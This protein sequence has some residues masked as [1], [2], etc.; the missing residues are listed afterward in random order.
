MICSPAFPLLIGACAILCIA[1]CRSASELSKVDANSRANGC[2][3]ASTVTDIDGNVYPVVQI[4]DQCWMAANLKT[5]RYRDG[6]I[7]P[8]ETDS[9]VWP[10]LTGGAWCHYGNSAVSDP[11]YGK[12][13]NWY[14]ASDPNICPQ[15]WHVPTDA[16]WAVLVD[17]L[18][19]KSIAGGRMKAVSPLWNAPNAGA[20]NES[21]FTG[22]PSGLRSHNGGGFNP[23]GD[24]GIWWSAS[25]SGADHA[26]SR[27]LGYHLEE[28]IRHDF[29]GKG[30]G[31]GL[32]CVRD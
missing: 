30:A 15:G 14:A 19:G 26:W 5:T 10:Q 4:G 7:I 28:V 21:G 31:L 9:T 8:H 6:R 1:S 13:Y 24:H 17:H 18:G 20:T 27:S 29:A 25:E 32:R 11:I 3:A 2:A 16:E 22:L 12:L 23:I